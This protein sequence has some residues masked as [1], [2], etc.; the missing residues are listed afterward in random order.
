MDEPNIIEKAK[1]LAGAMV[2]WAKHDGF[3]KVSDEVF[4]QRKQLCINCP[5]WD[6][7]A[8]AGL[9]MC[10]LCGCSVAKLYIPSSVCPDKPPRWPSV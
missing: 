10:K 6:P 3:A 9:G 2:G 7:N 1:N 8:Y 5:F 4:Q